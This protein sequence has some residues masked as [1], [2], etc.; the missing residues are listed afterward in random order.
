MHTHQWLKH[1]HTTVSD[2]VI[3]HPDEMEH[4]EQYQVLA[5]YQR[6]D[7]HQV[8]LFAG[9]VVHVIEKHDTGIEGNFYLR[10]QLF[11]LQWGNCI[12]YS[13]SVYCV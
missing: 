6:M 7:S 2:A 9:Q 3:S 10:K 12:K 4:L 11:C 1:A 8:N 13:C 5:N